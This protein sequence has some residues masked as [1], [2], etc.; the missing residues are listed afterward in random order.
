MLFVPF[1]LADFLHT[2]QTAQWLI[3]SEDLILQ[4][5]VHAV[6][7]YDGKQPEALTKR[8]CRLPHACLKWSVKYPTK[9]LFY[10]IIIKKF[11][12]LY[13]FYLQRLSTQSEKPLQPT[14]GDRQAAAAVQTQAARTTS[15]HEKQPLLCQGGVF[16]LQIFPF[17]N[18]EKKQN[19]YFM[20]SIWTW[21]VDSGLGCSDLCVCTDM[22]AC[23]V[24][25]QGYLTVCLSREWYSTLL[26]WRD[27]HHGNT[28]YATT[29][30]S[31][32]LTN[33]GH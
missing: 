13:L 26:H 21:Y 32:H 31:G 6:K 15:A 9:Y 10:K 8:S 14:G 25:G 22:K 2:R 33:L 3:Y 4:L 12:F 11:L 5:E 29:K 18:R 20:L 1:Q 30:S 19:M 23:D 17:R 24:A 28:P 27:L 16:N 7:S